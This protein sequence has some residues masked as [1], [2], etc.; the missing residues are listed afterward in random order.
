M[1]P[2]CLGLLREHAPWAR[3]AAHERGMA[4]LVQRVALSQL[5]RHFKYTPVRLAVAWAVILTFFTFLDYYSWGSLDILDC[6]KM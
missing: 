1:Q 2:S 6:S 4:N 5:L 3:D